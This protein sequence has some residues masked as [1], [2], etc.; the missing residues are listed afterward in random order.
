MLDPGLIFDFVHIDGEH[1]ED[2]IKHDL[3]ESLIRLA[4]G[5]FIA[6][7]DFMNRSFPGVTSATIITAAKLDLK[8]ILITESK[9]YVV[10]SRDHLASMIAVG[11]I[12]DDFNLGGSSQY[13]NGSYGESYSQ[14]G[15]IL[16]VNPFI[17]S[18]LSN[19]KIDQLLSRKLSAKRIV[20]STMY[21]ITPPLFRIFAR[22]VISI[23]RK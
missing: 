21:S 18:R 23:L 22:Y 9:I 19:L 6:I 17:Q 16:G 12:N 10:R 13:K 1:S 4:N 5:G 14:D 3:T 7:D 15:K 8:P 20:R 2:A 11:K